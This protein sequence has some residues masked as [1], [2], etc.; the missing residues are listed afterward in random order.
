MYEVTYSV[1]G[2]IKRIKIDAGDY[3]TAI[4]MVTNMFDTGKVQILDVIRG[5]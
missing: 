3:Q 1:D 5:Y 2:I 4:D